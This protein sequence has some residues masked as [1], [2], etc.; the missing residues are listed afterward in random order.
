MSIALL[1]ILA[2]TNAPAINVSPATHTYR[3][4]AT[5]KVKIVE[6]EKIGPVDRAAARKGHDRAVRRRGDIILVE[7]F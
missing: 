4:Q 3:K 1:L 5:A 7:F 6:V 2:S